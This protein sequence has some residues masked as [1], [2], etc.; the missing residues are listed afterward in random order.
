MDA[1]GSMRAS[2]DGT[3]IAFT[4][5]HNG[6]TSVLDFDPSTGSLSAPMDL[7]IPGGAYGISFS[8]SGSKLYV[9]VRSPIMSS[10]YQDGAL[11]QFDLSSGIQD[12]VQASLTVLHQCVGNG[13]FTT[14]KLG[15]D[16]RLY[17]ARVS[18]D[19]TS[20]GDPYLG[21]V[22]KP[23]LPGTACD[24]VHDGIWLNGAAGGWGLNNS[25]EY[26]HDCENV[27]AI[28]ELECNEITFNVQNGLQTATWTC[29]HAFSRLFVTAIDGRHILDEPIRSGLNDVSW[30][31]PDAA[32]GIYVAT[33]V[34][35]E[36]RVTQSFFVA[37]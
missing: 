21:V 30:K 18:S 11:V 3:R 9:S 22:N 37:Q 5:A 35:S 15:P 19:G 29:P 27:Q 32:S 26:G 4:T 16:G 36:Q 1:V 14:L 6:I 24:Y 25:I 2:P 28:P 10:T 23:D 12:A 20:S 13:G 7:S 17:V 31:M 34:G 33:L 8:P